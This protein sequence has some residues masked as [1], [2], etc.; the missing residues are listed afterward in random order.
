MT[1][2]NA[3]RAEYFD[4]IAPPGGW[5]EI[6]ELISLTCSVGREQASDQW[7][8][9]SGIIRARWR[10]SFDDTDLKV[11]SM[12]RWFA[13]GR[14]AT[15]PSWTGVVRNVRYIYDIPYA[16]GVGNGDILE[17]EIEGYLG[18]LGRQNIT[19]AAAPLTD[20]FEGYADQAWSYTNVP[21][22]MGSLL[23]ASTTHNYGTAL[24]RVAD[25]VQGRL[26]DGVRAAGTSDNP[27]VFLS[28]STDTP[29][30]TLKFSDTTNN[31]TNREYFEID[32]D[33]AADDFFTDITVTPELADPQQVQ[34]SIDLRA[35]DVLT[36]HRFN[37]SALDLARYLGV[38]FSTSTPTVSR[39][40]CRTPGQ[41]TQN[42][43]TLGVTDLEFGYLIKYR[44]QVVFRGVTY[45]AQIEGVNL[46]ADLDQS[47]FTYYLS[48]ADAG[49]WFTLDSA[50]YGRLNEDRL[51][52]V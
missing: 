3:Y 24:Q 9:S 11:G 21:D 34:T 47:T 18:V 36:W 1:V 19:Y 2:Y 40:A 35:L 42:L 48:P 38:K 25:T 12:I 39:I 41:Q 15:K 27:D 26:C 31:S 33:G 16:S 50:D 29:Q 51:G 28:A 7:P 32:F 17:I 10:D 30:L 45:W 46:V 49:Y 4:A 52:Y 20:Y 43:D 23:R 8:V 44:V 6:P 14:G 22:V 13:P 37:G 5:I